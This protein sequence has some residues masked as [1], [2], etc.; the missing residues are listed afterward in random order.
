[1]SSLVDSYGYWSANLGNARTPELS[2]SFSYSSSVDQVYLFGQI[3]PLG[4][5]CAFVDTSSDSPS[6]S[7]TSSRDARLKMGI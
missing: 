4:K 1:M 2:A 3:G 5:D 7:L 6:Q